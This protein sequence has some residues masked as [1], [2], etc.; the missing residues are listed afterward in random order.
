MTLQLRPG[1]DGYTAFNDGPCGQRPVTRGWW[2]F[3]HP[4]QWMAFSACEE[5]ARFLVERPWPVSEQR[6]WLPPEEP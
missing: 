1:A 5:H 3:S 2:F 4:R 6:P